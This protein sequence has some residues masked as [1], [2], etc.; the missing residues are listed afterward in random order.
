MPSLGTLAPLPIHQ[1]RKW[2]NLDTLGFLWRLHAS[3]GVMIKSLVM[4]D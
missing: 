2:L 4:S 3:I 1:G